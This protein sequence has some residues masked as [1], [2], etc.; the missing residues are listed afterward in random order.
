MIQNRYFSR[1]T[2]P[3]SDTLAASH[4]SRQVGEALGESARRL[5]G[6]QPVANS[7]EGGTGRQVSATLL[8]SEF[9][10]KRNE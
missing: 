2:W 7:Q 5:P 3:R 6:Q 10:H 9:Q 1:F 4:H 8:A